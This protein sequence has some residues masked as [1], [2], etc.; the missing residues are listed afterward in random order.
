MKWS[1]LGKASATPAPAKAMR[2]PAPAPTVE[3]ETPVELKPKV[4]DFPIDAGRQLDHQPLYYKIQDRLG[5]IAAAIIVL[6][7]IM[8]FC[9][10]CA[11][12]QSWWDKTD[13][14]PP[15]MDYKQT[16]TAAVLITI[17]SAILCGPCVLVAG[18]GSWIVA[19]AARYDTV[20]AVDHQWSQYCDRVNIPHTWRDEHFAALASISRRLP[21]SE[22]AE[23]AWYTYLAFQYGEDLPEK[24]VSMTGKEAKAFASMMAALKEQ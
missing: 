7:I 9:C 3:E 10:G 24:H 19:A 8:H 11:S 13:T 5:G 6:L 16:Q 14:P 1:G 17:G 2:K 22:R 18:P 15:K 21:P 20:R 12:V 4:Y 23:W